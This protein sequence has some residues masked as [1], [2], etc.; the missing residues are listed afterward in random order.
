METFSKDD[1]CEYVHLPTVPINGSLPVT[2]G[3]QMYRKYPGLPYRHDHT[4]HDGAPSPTSPSAIVTSVMHIHS[5]DTNLKMKSSRFSVESVSHLQ[6]IISSTALTSRILRTAGSSTIGGASTIALA[7]DD[8][9][10]PEW[11]TW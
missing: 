2:D 7:V 10:K 8:C 9:V 11:A 3:H 1:L 6:L 5:D 4:G